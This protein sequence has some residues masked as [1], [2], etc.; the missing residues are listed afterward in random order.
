MHTPRTALLEIEWVI[1]SPDKV[2]SPGASTHTSFVLSFRPSGLAGCNRCQN[3]G[4]PPGGDGAPKLASSSAGLPASP[5]QNGQLGG[6]GGLWEPLTKAWLPA[7]FKDTLPAL[8]VSK[9]VAVPHSG[10]GS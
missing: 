7:A 9:A 6:A 10:Y 1:S 4:M 2:K 8:S 3:W 5:P